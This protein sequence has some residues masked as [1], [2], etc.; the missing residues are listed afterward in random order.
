M[1]PVSGGTSRYAAS[2]RRPS[3]LIGVVIRVAW[4][5]TWPN[6]GAP[7]ASRNTASAQASARG[8]TFAARA[9][10]GHA[11]EAVQCVAL[12]NCRVGAIRVAE[13]IRLVP[14][15]R[16]EILCVIPDG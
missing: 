10:V 9:D 5:R 7:G 16:F 2:S 12:R 8:I 15:P 11:G 3:I 1:N 4:I 14:Q 6:A 13:S